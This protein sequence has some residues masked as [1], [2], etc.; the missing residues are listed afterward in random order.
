MNLH[1]KTKT[2]H[3]RVSEELHAKLLRF[4]PEKGDIAFVVRKLL[5]LH[6]DK[7]EE[8]E[9]DG[10]SVTSILVSRAPQLG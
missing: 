3:F 6:L 9:S 1:R 7:L 5:T 10:I 2:L 4:Y 8:F